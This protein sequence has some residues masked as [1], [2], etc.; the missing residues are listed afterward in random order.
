MPPGS[1]N[2]GVSLVRKF[3]TNTQLIGLANPGLHTL[4]S[5]RGDEVQGSGLRNLK[6][7]N[8]EIIRNKKK[9]NY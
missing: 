4:H 7:V 3:N 5:Q 8:N 6:L 1:K 2:N 9:S